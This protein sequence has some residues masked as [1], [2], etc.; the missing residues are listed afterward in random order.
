LEERAHPFTTIDASSKPT[1]IFVPPGLNCGL[2]SGLQSR[3]GVGQIDLSFGHAGRIMLLD[4][5]LRR[6]SAVR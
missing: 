4:G 3:E 5:E 2:D 6:E 1:S